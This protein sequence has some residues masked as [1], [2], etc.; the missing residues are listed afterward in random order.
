MSSTAPSTQTPA[1]ERALALMAERDQVDQQLQAHI[2][3]L[4]SHGVTMSTRLV[5][6]QG[7][8]RADLDLVAIR[9]TRVRVIELRNDRTRLTN[10]IAQALADVHNS[11]PPQ[12]A[13]EGKINGVDGTIEPSPASTP[14]VTLL[15]P[16][17][18]V[19]GVAPGSP[20]QQAGLQR[21]DLILAFGDLTARSF[22][23]SS[24]Q[25]LAQLVTSH[26]NRPLTVRI[27]RNGSEMNL[28]FT[29]RSGWGG[30]GML[31]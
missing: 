30:R 20:A 29:P 25:P 9:T 28:S 2:S 11:L 23:G 5:D 13:S 12:P 8:P 21:E 17:A 26:E 31:G 18:R 24:L 4:T 7:F 22:S 19:D 6:G 10:E 15:A 14:G 1:Q 3:T 16:F 27:K